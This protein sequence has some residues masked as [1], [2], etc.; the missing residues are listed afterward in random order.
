M[1]KCGPKLKAIA[2]PCY[3]PYG[4][5]LLGPFLVSSKEFLHIAKG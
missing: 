2:Q 4:Y 3:N 1:P 5:Q